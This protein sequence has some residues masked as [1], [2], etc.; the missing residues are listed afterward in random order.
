MKSLKKLLISSLC[1]TVLVLGLVGC[2]G[3]KGSESKGIDDMDKV[4]IGVL[5]YD[6]T[7][8]EVVAFKNYYTQY[9]AKQYPVEFIYSD[10]ITTAEEEIAAIENFV[11]LKVKGIVSFSDQDRVASIKLCEEAQIYYAIG[12][13]TLS[14]DKY[15]EL[16]GYKYY[17]GSVGPTLA[18]EKKV[19]Y[20][21]AKY[22]LE[23]GATNFLVY[24]GGYPFVEMH[25]ERTE[26]MI[27]AFE[28]VGI[29]YTPGDNGTFGKLEGA[30]YTINTISGFP[31]EAGAFWG[32]VGQKVAEQNLE[33]VLT[34]C[35][36]VEF[37]GAAISQ[38]NPNIKLATVASFTESYTA[39]FNASPAQV[40]YLA[41]KYG[42]S[43]GP[44]FAALFNCVTGNADVTRDNGNAF[45]LSQDYWVAIGTEQYNKMS[46][47][48]N[49]TENPAY[50]KADLDKYIKLI[51]ENTTF[52]EFKKFTEA[53]SFEDIEAMHK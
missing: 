44:I 53:S 43:I 42:S 4:K 14:D 21:M 50:A 39:A 47:I 48:A 12:A 9:L 24:A 7:D 15:N 40:D 26:G 37:F 25:R 10:S 11:N 17:V 23:S 45:N 13:G 41:G 49:S 52:E 35:L 22:Y 1:L 19:G 18:N 2:G 33:V 46:D 8:S 31:D 27:Q 16:K 6:S 3:E 30:G 28:E 29:I 34:S 36:G 20:E 5:I 32:T 51:N 38:I